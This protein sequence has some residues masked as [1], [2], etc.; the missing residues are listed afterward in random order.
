MKEQRI[1]FVGLGHMGQP[2]ALNLLKAGIDVCVYDL[3]EERVAPL[4]ALGASQAFRLQDVGEP[5]GIVLTMVPDDAALLAVTEGAG[6]LIK[7]LGMGGIHLSLSTI[8]PHIS[9]HLAQQY[10]HTGGFYLSATVLGRPDV[11]ANAALSIF[12]SGASCAKQRVFPLLEVLGKRMYDLGE[13]VKAANVVKL[14]A[15]FLIL[16]ALEAMGEA[17]SFV[18][19]AGVDRALFLRM[20]VESPLFAGAVYEGY[21]KMIGSQDYRDARFPVHMGLKDAQLVLQTAERSGVPLP[22]AQVARDHLLAAQAHG[23]ER[24]DWAVLAEFVKDVT[25]PV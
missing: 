21:G 2:M 10:R 3:N 18:E 23:R 5:G 19:D 4:I 24:E 17:A 9:E 7:R 12:L 11:A 13:D 6:G 25:V 8:S 20:M 1:W 22:L 16:A 14:G 15:N